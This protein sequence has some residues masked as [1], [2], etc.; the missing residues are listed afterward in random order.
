MGS[1]QVLSQR[2]AFTL[3]PAQPSDVIQCY[4]RRRHKGLNHFF[5]PTYELF[6]KEGDQFLLAARKRKKRAKDVQYLISTDRACIKREGASYFG[7]LK[8]NWRATEF[9]I[10]DG[11]VKPE[12]AREAERPQRRRLAS[13]TY[14]RSLRGSRASRKMKVV[15]PP[16]PPPG[17]HPLPPRLPGMRAMSSV[18]GVKED[19]AAAAADEA[20]NGVALRNRPLRW[21]DDMAAYV[22]VINGYKVKA[23]KKNFAL[24]PVS[25][26][27][28]GETTMNFQ[29]IG[30]NNLFTLDYSA[31]L[32]AAQAFGIA[33]SSFEASNKTR[34]S[35]K[36]GGRYRHRRGRS[37]RS[38]KIK[39]TMLPASAAAPA[40][41]QASVAAAA[42]AAPAMMTTTTTTT[43]TRGS[44][45]GDG[46]VTPTGSA[47]PAQEQRVLHSEKI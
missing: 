34:P 42:A 40:E 36:L 39:R 11:G 24:Q 3:S 22:T 25:A 18:V 32:C 7:K 10:F 45:I 37:Q 14:H 2:V 30:E 9:Q 8:G 16:L 47:G 1:L 4:I 33:L 13:V 44:A 41:A 20:T 28:D 17:S 43:T 27:G 23:S 31:P 15:L 6:L 21:D 29:R 26:H 12:I 19:D 38:L 5:Y 35:T 46:L